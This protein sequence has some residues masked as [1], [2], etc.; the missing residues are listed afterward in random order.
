MTSVALQCRIH[1][2]EKMWRDNEVIFHDNNMAEPRTKI[3]NTRNNGVGHTAIILLFSNCYLSKSSDGS[4]IFPHF[5]HF[6]TGSL[7]FRPVGKNKELAFRCKAVFPEGL[8]GKPCMFG[9]VI[10]KKG[11]WG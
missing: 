10:D 9:P 4:D 11:D 3:T 6:F 7:I 8:Y 5:L 1:I 2:L